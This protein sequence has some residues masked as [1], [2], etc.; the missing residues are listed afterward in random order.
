LTASDEEAE[1]A[2]RTAFSAHFTLRFLFSAIAR[3]ML[4]PWLIA[5]L[6]ISW[7]AGWSPR[8]T[9]VAAPM[10]VPGAIAAMCAACA[11]KVPALIA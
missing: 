2:L 1:V 3:I 9:G 7:D 11:M 6:F 8:K 4:A 10:F 5:F